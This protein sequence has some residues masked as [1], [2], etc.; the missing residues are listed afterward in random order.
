M[1]IKMLNP[2]Y[3]EETERLVEWVDKG[4]LDADLLIDDLICRMVQIID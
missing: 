3:C 2:D 4:I 1:N